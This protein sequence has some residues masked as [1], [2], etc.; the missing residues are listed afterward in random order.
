MVAG[1]DQHRDL[2][3]AQQRPVVH[4]ADSRATSRVTN[5]VGRMQ[6]SSNG[7]LEIAP[8][9][10]GSESALGEINRLPSRA[11]ISPL[12]FEQ[13]KIA[14]DRGFFAFGNLSARGNPIEMGTI[15]VGRRL[16]SKLQLAERSPRPRVQDASEARK[17]F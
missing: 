17:R 4:I 16:E 8:C 1:D 7:L 9:G 2:N 3:T 5:R 10:R 6:D 14:L 12:P 13:R 15:G 11:D